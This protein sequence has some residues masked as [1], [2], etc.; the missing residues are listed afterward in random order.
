MRHRGDILCRGGEWRLVYTVRSTESDRTI[1]FAFSRRELYAV[2]WVMKKAIYGQYACNVK[3]FNE[4][5]VDTGLRDVKVVFTDDSGTALI[6]SVPLS[7]ESGAD[8]S[9]FDLPA[10]RWV[11]ET[12]QGRIE[13]EKFEDIARSTRLELRA[14]LPA[15]K[16]LVRE[17]RRLWEAGDGAG[18]HKLP[19]GASE[20]SQDNVAPA[21]ERPWWRR[22]FGG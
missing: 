11:S 20:G 5:E 18:R 6:T 12:F 13:T 3:M 1:D 16:L 14:Y 7:T 22:V 21:R 9:V 2:E 19:P 10:R 4:A 8:P 15:D 17:I